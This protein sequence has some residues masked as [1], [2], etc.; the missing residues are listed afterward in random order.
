M[1]PHS[2]VAG[3]SADELLERAYSLAGQE[4]ALELYHDWAAT[5]DETMTEGLHYA[6]PRRCAGLLARHLPDKSDRILDVGC[7]TGLAAGELAKLGFENFDGIDIS[8]DM[9]ETA[10][11]RA[12]YK[13][14]EV[15]DLLKP[16]QIETGSY[17]AAISTG[18]F[19]HAHVGSGCLAELFRV[20]KPGGLFAFTV[21]LDV[22]EPQGF[23]RELG[24]LQ[25]E[26]IA[27]PVE[28]FLGSYFSTADEP[29]GRYCVY[30][31]L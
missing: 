21:H 15:A 29:E 9:L 19:T 5:Y 22:W 10:K 14:L 25:A 30:R 13:R 16:L 28:M 7:G 1:G 8:P 20:L 4:D 17:D 12:I 27:D 11:S 23:G 26:R 6:S 3:T 31:R 2:K 18:T 24:R